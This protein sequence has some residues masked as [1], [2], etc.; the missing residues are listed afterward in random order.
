MK[1][2]RR[3]NSL[4]LLI[5]MNMIQTG[6]R[7]VM[8]LAVHLRDNRLIQKPMGS[9]TIPSFSFEDGH[10]LM[11]WPLMIKEVTLR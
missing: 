11:G 9:I 1:N 10:Q 4:Q 7:M 2:G 8:F 6:R 3:T 5:M